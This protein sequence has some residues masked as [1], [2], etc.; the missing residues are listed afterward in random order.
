MISEISEQ[1]NLLALNAAIEAARVGEHGRGFAVVAE[2]VR[3][4]AE[5]SGQATKEIADLVKVIQQDIGK[6]VSAAKSGETMTANVRKA[7]DQI[8]AMVQKN[9][10]MVQK[11]SLAAAG[12]EKG[13]EDVAKSSESISAVTEEA[14]ASIEEIAASAVEMSGMAENLQKIVQQFK[15]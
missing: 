15:G 11:M 6:A 1:T 5:R 2:E 12:A 9:N 8:Y 4:L 3:K 10:D 14:A 13:V 7:F